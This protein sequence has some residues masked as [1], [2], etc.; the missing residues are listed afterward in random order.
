MPVC[1]HAA[2]NNTIQISSF[3]LSKIETEELQNLF[4]LSEYFPLDL[5]ENSMFI[6]GLD[7][8]NPEDITE[9]SLPRAQGIAG[10]ALQIDRSLFQTIQSLPSLW[11]YHII[12]L[13][14]IIYSNFWEQC[15]RNYFHFWVTD[16]LAWI[17]LLFVAGIH[18][19][20]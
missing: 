13:W 12:H 5:A 9:S 2:G 16:R 18:L 19:I 7:V 17:S 20:I 8:L 14:F 4:Q 6:S 1:N 15:R 10:A 11:V 3:F